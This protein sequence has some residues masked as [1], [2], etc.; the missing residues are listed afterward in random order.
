MGEGITLQLW[1]GRGNR[2][3]FPTQVSVSNCTEFH[4]NIEISWKMANSTAQLEI[5]HLWKIV[6]PSYEVIPMTC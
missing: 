3:F 5:L 6:D 4:S 1:D 2:V